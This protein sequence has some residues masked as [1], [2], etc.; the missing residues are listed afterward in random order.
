MEVSSMIQTKAGRAKVK[1]SWYIK[2]RDICIARQSARQQENKEEYQAYQKEYHKTY[3]DKNANERARKWRQKH[4]EYNY[5]ASHAE[6]CKNQAKIFRETHPERY[7]VANKISVARR[8]RLIIQEPCAICN[9]TKTECHHFDYSL[10]MC[11][12]HL[13]RKCHSKI[14]SGEL[15]NKQIQEVFVYEI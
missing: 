1:H 7:I 4:P 14:H 6:Q 8:S 2:N 11:V 15:N 5:Y 12:V 3:E 10:P 9:E 13:C